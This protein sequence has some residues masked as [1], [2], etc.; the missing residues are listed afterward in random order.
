MDSDQQLI[1]SAGPDTVH[2]ILTKGG[3]GSPLPIKTSGEVGK[4]SNSSSRLGIL[5]KDLKKGVR[6]KNPKL[7]RKKDLEKI[8]STEETLVESGVVK[9]L[10]SH[11]LCTQK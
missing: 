5:Q 4:S 8:K 2:E 7:G 10:D 11:F 9:P 1:V 6:E 3:E